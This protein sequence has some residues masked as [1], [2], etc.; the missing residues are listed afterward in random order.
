MFGSGFSYHMVGTLWVLVV[1]IYVH[2]CWLVLIVWLV[3]P[4]NA[5]TYC[6]IL[7]KVVNPK[8]PPPNLQ[9]NTQFVI[10]C[11]LQGMGTKQGFILG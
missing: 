7:C 3:T 2:M 1:F 5:E 11:P 9:L 8:T 6:T 10:F 4:C